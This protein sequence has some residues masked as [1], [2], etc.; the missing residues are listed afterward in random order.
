MQDVNRL[1]LLLLRGVYRLLPCLFLFACHSRL[2][3]QTTYNLRH[4]TTD[5]GLPQN[6]VKA[7]C[8]DRAGY[9]WLATEMGLVRYDGRAFRVFGTANL[10]GIA[11]DR[12]QYM[13][14]SAA[15]DVYAMTA[16]IEL[17]E[18]CHPAGDYAPVPARRKKTYCLAIAAWRST[19]PLP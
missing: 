9:C 1:S 2:E 16:S 18:V 19:T 11:S 7:V 6:S 13:L 15:G 12:I 8:F 5:N 4:Y 10:K 14:R 17:L 3:G